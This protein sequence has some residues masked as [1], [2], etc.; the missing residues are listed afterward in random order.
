MKN[1]SF[2]KG[3]SV[4]RKKFAGH[5]YFLNSLACCVIQIMHGQTRSHNSTIKDLSVLSNPMF[6]KQYKYTALTYHVVFVTTDPSSNTQFCSFTF[7]TEIELRR[8]FP[9]KRTSGHQYNDL[10][11]SVEKSDVQSE[12]AATVEKLQF[13]ER[14]RERETSWQATTNGNRR[15]RS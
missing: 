4:T 3:N 14:E 9:A 5:P 15:R 13:L 10:L 2:L 1:K 6:T 11:R 8:I 7:S 12:K